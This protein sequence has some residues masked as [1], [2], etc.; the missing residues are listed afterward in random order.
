VGKS[1][2]RQKLKHVVPVLIGNLQKSLGKPKYEPIRVLLD[3]GT[4]GTIILHKYVQKLRTKQ[5]QKPTLWKTKGGNF[6]TAQECKILFQLPELDRSKVIEWNVHVDTTVSP[7][8]SKYDMIMGTDLL[9]ALGI[10]LDFSTCMVTWDNATVPM[11]DGDLLSTKTQ[12]NYLFEESYES[13]IV[14]DATA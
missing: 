10:G 5:S 9:K 1:K 2:K 3:S 8:M 12:L 13:D 4:T 6:T 11:R 7:H 14:Q